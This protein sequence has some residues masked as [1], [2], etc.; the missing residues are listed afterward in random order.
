M[1][2]GC[3]EA[4]VGDVGGELGGEGLV[5]DGVFLYRFLFGTGLGGGGGDGVGVLLGPGEETHEEGRSLGLCRVVVF[6]P[7]VDAAWAQK[8]WVEFVHVV[9]LFIQKISKSVHR[10][11][12][13]NN[14]IK[15]DS[16]KEQFPLF[17]PYSV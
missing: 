2:F 15:T 10:R 12:E 16:C 8:S 17:T 9:C 7:F 4:G 14:K 1:E 11:G 5:V 3:R 6:Y 13:R